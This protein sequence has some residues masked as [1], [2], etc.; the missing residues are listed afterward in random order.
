[1]IYGSVCGGIEAFSC[2][3]TER[4]W[5]ASFIS[6]IADFPRAVIRHRFPETPLHGDFTTIQEGDY[7]PIQLLIGGTPCQ[8]FS[9]AG[10]R[11][12]LGDARGVLAWEFLALA[13]RL[14]PQWI[15]WENVTGALSSGE[16][17]DFASLITGMVECG[18]GIAWRV[19][20]TRGFGI[21]Q[22]RRRLFVLGYRGNWRPAFAALHEQG[23]LFG[24]P[25]AGRSAAD[26]SAAAIAGSAGKRAE[27][28]QAGLG[29]IAGFFRML[30]FGKYAPDIY[31]STMKARDHKDATDLIVHRM[32]NG[33]FARKLSISEREKLMGF[34]VGWTN[35]SWKG[36]P[37]PESLRVHALGNSMVV[38]VM[39]WLIDRI[40]LI[41]GI[42]KGGALCSEHSSAGFIA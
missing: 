2:A 39:E 28:G 11:G 36:R 33:L 4:G 29:E 5:K 6:E 30:K 32:Q 38:P 3:A 17:E 9:I 25:E 16:G 20:D 37:A 24:H 10:G 23:S 13:E 22:G 19:L 27:D 35:V 8:S 26:R 7:G 15:L 12:G 1:M 18:Y 40:D 41:E 34:P 21:P 31:A 14:R 42:M